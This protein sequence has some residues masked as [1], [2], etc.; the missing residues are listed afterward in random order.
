[1]LRICN[2]RSPRPCKWLNEVKGRI[3][4]RLNAG[5]L[6]QTFGELLAENGVSGQ[7][8]SSGN[9]ETVG[10]FRRM[11]MTI[12]FVGRYAEVL[13][14]LRE[15]EH[16]GRLVR[17]RQLTIRHQQDDD[18]LLSITLKIDAFGRSST[19]QTR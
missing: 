5:E 4:D 7:D 9:I 11:P 6:L 17:L 14:V 16:H 19:Q 15:L 12:G 10:A 8:I 13:R 3:P 1:M 2:H 18:Q